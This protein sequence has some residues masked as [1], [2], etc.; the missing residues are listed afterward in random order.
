[1]MKDRAACLGG[2]GTSATRYSRRTGQSTTGTLHKAGG[3]GDSG[4]SRNKWSIPKYPD[5]WKHS[6]GGALFKLLLEWRTEAHKGKSQNYLSDHFSTV[7]ESVNP[8]GTGRSRSK[9]RRANATS[10]AG[11]GTQDPTAD[12]EDTAGG[13]ATSSDEPPRKR[14][15][16]QKSR[17]IV[18]ER[19]A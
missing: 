1:M 11:T 4:A 7:M 3:S 17:Q 5:T 10:P 15:R 8:P 13:D 2:D 12:G 16:L 14:I 9:S 18:T 6:F 19:S